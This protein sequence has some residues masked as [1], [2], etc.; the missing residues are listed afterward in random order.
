ML[1]RNYILVFIVLANFWFKPAK[2]QT[3]AEGLRA[4]DFEKY[5][6]AKKIFS[7]LTAQNPANPEYWYYLGQA[8]F[9][10]LNNE[11]ART[12]YEQGIS[13][14]PDY[15]QNYA[16]LGQL[17]LDAEKINE[18]RSMFDKA[19]SFSR[20]K[21][22]YYTDMKLVTAVLTNMIGTEKKLLDE[23][24]ALLVKQYEFDKQNYDFLVAAGDVYLERNDGGK[25]ATFYE[26]A[27]ALDPANPKAYSRVA[28]IWLRV[29]NL[30][31]AQSDLNRAFE[32]DP[33]YA[34]ALKYQAEL[35]YAQRN[36]QKAKEYYQK[37][38]D[39]SEPS[40]ANRI[41]FARLLYLA[42]EYGESLNQIE[43]ILKK[44]KSN[45]SLFKL[46]A[47]AIAELN[48]I[49]V[50]KE[51]VADGLEAM[52]YFISK[53]DAEKLNA[54]DYLYLGK[55]QAKNGEDSL[56]IES[57]TKSLQL[58]PQQWNVY[59][60]LGKLYFNKKDFD[61]SVQNYDT[62]FANAAK[63]GIL[64]YFYYG[65]AAYY[66]KQYAKA[67]T[68][69]QKIAEMNKSY[70]EA[71]F[72]RG[73][74][75]SGLDPDFTTDDA[76]LAYEKYIEMIGDD[77]AKIEKAKSNLITAYSYLGYYYLNKDMNVQAKNYY[78]KVLELDPTNKNANEVLKKLK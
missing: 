55:L 45:L 73:N 40:V 59:A 22:G 75:L 58:N 42:K 77:A 7:A 21:Q 29:K 18:A 20:K 67:D 49:K 53:T 71:Y 28:V 3:L 32:K 74:C 17:L 2:A 48:E 38:L 39:N 24:E 33:L 34:P 63:P 13:V 51:Q 41:K 56:A 5:E 68:A 1:K 46:K 9:N 25:A 69:F 6:H 15:G 78:K 70:A 47:F 27:I 76:K 4:L 52:K 36:Y 44:D 54:Y 14:K 16:G 72:W 50:N 64:D 65:R 43:E 26:R 30:E 19:L 8:N 62:Y 23:A 60:E 12:A 57:F 37:Y 10:L 66:G 11:E 31:A 35:Y 61:K